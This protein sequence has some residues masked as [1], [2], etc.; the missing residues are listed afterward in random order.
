MLYIGMW[1][2]IKNIN[3]YLNANP[4][5]LHH[6]KWFQINSKYL[7]ENVTLNLLIIT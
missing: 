1:Y 4:T 6:G 5:V 7:K 3:R 2:I